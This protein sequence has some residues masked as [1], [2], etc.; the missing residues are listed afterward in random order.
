MCGR[1]SL[2][3]NKEEISKRFNVKTPADF[4]PRY[5]VA[6]LQQFPIITS[7]NPNELTMVRWGLVPSWSLDATTAANMI[8][9]RAESITTKIPFKHCLKDQRC[10]IPADGFYE[11]KK[12]GKA[13]IPF[14]F[15]LSNEDL[16]CFAG[17][18]DA[19]ENQETGIILNTFTIITTEANKLVSDVHERMPVILRK[20]LEKLWIAET[21][22]DS[23]INSLLKPYDTSLMTSYKAHKSVNSVQN[24]SPDCI[25][26]APKIYPGETFS[27]FD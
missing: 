8:N 13:K 24:D 5:N 18:W 25:L 14:R 11:W 9:A 15:T 23:Q 1:F 22:T 26:A 27:L 3:K 12:E 21:I 10:L 7:R 2:A 6:P 17:L 4:K 16:F 19:W 20:D